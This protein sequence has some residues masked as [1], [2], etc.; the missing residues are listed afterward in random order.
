MSLAGPAQYQILKVDKTLTGGETKTADIRGKVV[1]FD[2]YESL[3][4]PMITANVVVVDTGN[5]V[6]D[7]NG[8]LAT[9]KDGMPIVADGTE[10]VEFQIATGNG[11]LASQKPMMITGTP[12]NFDQSTRQVLN[13]PLVSEFSIDN[14]RKP[15]EG[16]YGP[17]PISDIVQK[18]LGNN[19]L[20][21]FK[22][23]IEKTVNHDKIQGRNESAIDVIL[24]LAKK[25]R[26][27]TNGSPGY[28]F[29]E[30]Q[31]GFNFRSIEGLISEGIREYKESEDIQDIRTYSYFNNQKQDLSTNK[32]DFKLVLM[33]IVKRDQNL[34]NALRTGTHNVRIQ[35]KNLLTGEFTDNVVNLLNKNSTFL[36]DQPDKQEKQKTGEYCKTF[37][38]VIAPGENEN[39][40]SSK[41]ENN[42]AEYEPEALMRY[43]M[44]H[45]QILDIQVPCN[46]QLMAG[47][48]IKL[49]LENV[50]QG[51]KLV[52]KDNPH[53]SGFYLILHLRHH[54][55][56]KHSYT[57]MTIA[58]DTYG[59]YRS[60]K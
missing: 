9:I 37:T 4:S 19:E 5:S 6:T 11:T 8:Q 49:N 36:G 55:D 23:N 33:P 39:E 18:I 1:D 38:Y 12:L 43:A 44:L 10:T 22:D 27:A 53:R 2:Y 40:S 59:L 50:T 47:Q 24:S 21:F 35:T 60:S 25:S 3:Y 48:V 16:N 30:T 52:E 32:D 41:I 14:A 51:N 15:L 46:V 45:S 20:L 7:A 31:E 29:Y 56:P 26:P 13:L 34:L 54:F 28:F 57:S 17:A 58:R 42:P